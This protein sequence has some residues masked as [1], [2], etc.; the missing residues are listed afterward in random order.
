MSHRDIL[1]DYSGSMLCHH[2]LHCCHCLLLCGKMIFKST[3]VGTKLV[4]FDQSTVIN[5]KKLEGR[6]CG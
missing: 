6:M 1:G 2:H 4:F 3:V 5:I